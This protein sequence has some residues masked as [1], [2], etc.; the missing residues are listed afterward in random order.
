VEDD[1]LFLVVRNK[2]EVAVL[3]KVFI[4]VSMAASRVIAL[5]NFAALRSPIAF[6]AVNP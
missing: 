6:A 1:N 5:V 3:V 4:L 2:D